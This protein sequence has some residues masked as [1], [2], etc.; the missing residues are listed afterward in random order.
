MIERIASRYRPGAT[1]R[2]GWLRIPC[3]SHKGRGNNLA[4]SV[5]ADDGLILKCHSRQC[6]YN[7][8]LE[9]FR[10]DGIEIERTWTYPRGERVH[11]TDAPGKPKQIRSVGTTKGVGLLIR[12]DKAENTL[13][14]VEGESD[15]DAL[16]SAD[17][18]EVTATC[19]VGGAAR[20]RVADYSVVGGRSVVV[21]GDN[22]REGQAAARHA[23]Q[24]CYLS[25]AE[26]VRIVAPVGPEKGG[27]ADLT[28]EDMRRAIDS[29]RVVDRPAAPVVLG[30]DAPVAQDGSDWVIGPVGAA[31]ISCRVRNLVTE[32]G[33]LYGDLTLETEG[34]VFR[35]VLHFP[36]GRM[37]AC[38]QLAEAHT[39][40]QHLCAQNGPWEQ[41]RACP[42]T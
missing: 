6:A 35:Q 27:A 41:L 42:W 30:A 17:L 36:V 34:T 5:G 22:D 16:V 23:A 25:G 1:L 3:P 4:I 11:R 14:I 12:K 8:I 24:K 40:G 20:A 9:A 39:V 7:D 26:S 33:Q 29:A 37:T 32:N 15:A 2:K 10:R 31:G 13:V 19:W 38:T 21:W 28:P 18:E